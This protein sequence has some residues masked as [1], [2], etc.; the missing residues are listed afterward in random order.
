[1][2]RDKNIPIK[3]YLIV[4]FVSILIIIVALYARAFY[5]NYKESKS[6]SSYFD[7]KKVN[8]IT[9]K[10]IKY[11]LSEYRDAILYVGYTGSYPVYSS[12]KKI[13][14][15]L[16]KNNLLD[17]LL[18][19]DVSDLTKDSEY[20]NMLKTEFKDLSSDIKDV[21]LIII[22]KDG[23]PIEVLNS[24]LEKIDYKALRNII[25]KNEIE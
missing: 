9:T 13:Y 10:D 12:E 5:I 3:N 2:K 20:V 1:M 8:K 15:E 7:V 11:T 23:K 25:K 18:Y 24:E 21:P 6:V 17:I 14:K 22:I 4:L 16:E 19:L